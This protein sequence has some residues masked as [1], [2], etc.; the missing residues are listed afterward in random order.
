MTRRADHGKMKGAQRHAEGE[1]GPATRA[2]IRQEVQEPHAERG[3]PGP[4]QEPRNAHEPDGTHRLFERREQHDP[5]DVQSDKNR[6][7]KDIARHDHERS[8]FAVPG[9]AAPHPKMPP[10]KIDPEHPDSRD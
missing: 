2:R 6:L 9:G 10:E 4:G 7:M 3:E 5:A 8:N 1:H